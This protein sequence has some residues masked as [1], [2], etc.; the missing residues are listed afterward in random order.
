MRIRQITA[1]GAA[2][3]ALM[4]GA[5]LPAFAADAQPVAAGAPALQAKPKQKVHVWEDAK[6]KG[7]DKYFTKNAPHL[8][9][10]NDTISS[11]KNLGKRTVS[12]YI[13]AKYQGAHIAL[14]EGQS[15]AHFGNRGVGD[16]VSS[17]KFG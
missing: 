9:G 8:G 14:A 2:A 4:L 17:I 16:I 6:Y 13:T 1:A 15:E 10:W 7:K 11:A 12:F 5:A 3:T